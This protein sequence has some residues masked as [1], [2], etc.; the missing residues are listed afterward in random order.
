LLFAEDCINIC[1]NS[2]IKSGHA[3]DVDRAI[4]Q[5]ALFFACQTSKKSGMT[6]NSKPLKVSKCSVEEHHPV[7]AWL[8]ARNG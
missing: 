4:D 6:P 2:T 3:M 7:L 8:E 1:N 5:G